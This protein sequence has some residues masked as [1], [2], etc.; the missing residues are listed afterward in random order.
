MKYNQ[1]FEE[2]LNESSEV[3]E[4]VK[5][6]FVAIKKTK[7]PILALVKLRSPLVTI[8]DA[9]IRFSS[10]KILQESKMKFEHSPNLPDIEKAIEYYD[11]ELQ[12]FSDN[13][14]FDPE[15]FSR[16]LSLSINRDRIIQ[17]LKYGVR[18]TKYC[19][20]ESEK[21]TVISVIGGAMLSTNNYIDLLNSV[22]N[23]E[24]ERR[25]TIGAPQLETFK[26]ISWNDIGIS[27][28][29]LTGRLAQLN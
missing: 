18:A 27:G 12:V 3:L 9:L 25:L 2:V 28:E 22:L 14:E 5:K 20:E 11:Q 29:N 10:S 1:L 19:K 13:F 8:W 6:S 16:A 24:N 23:Q 15:K 17:S 4:R 7:D 21:K 26:N